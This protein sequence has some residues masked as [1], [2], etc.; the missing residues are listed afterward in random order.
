LFSESPPLKRKNSD[1]PLLQ[2]PENGTLFSV[3]DA[4]GAGSPGQEIAE[5]P[6]CKAPGNRVSL[7]SCS[8]AIHG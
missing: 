4:G 2:Q 3:P 6:I 5:T 1:Q 7:K 8:G